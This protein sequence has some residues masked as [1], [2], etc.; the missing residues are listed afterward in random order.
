[1]ALEF[2]QMTGS[3]FDLLSP[4]KTVFFFPV[5]PLEDYG[6]HLPLGL[7]LAEATSL[8]Q[9]MAQ[10]IETEMQG[11]TAVIMPT[12][13][14]GLDTATSKLALSVRPHVL[15]DWLVDACDG[16]IRS[17]HLHFVCF[18][19]N[20]GPKQL[21]AIEEAGALIQK[22]TR[23][24]RFWRNLSGRRALQPL[25]ALISA[26]SAKVSPQTVWQSPLFFA[27][28]EHGGRR[29]TSVA[30]ALDPK[31]VISTFAA[32]PGKERP[33]S[34]LWRQKWVHHFGK[35]QGYWGKPAE[36][37]AQWGESV[38]QETIQELFPKIKAVLEG[39]DPQLL[40]RSWY[41]IF[42]SNRTFFKAWML[43]FAFG[44]VLLTWV[45]LNLWSAMNI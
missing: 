40:F 24:R 14:L 9:R 18:S 30:L 31:K 35:S 42:P 5:G 3:Q 36:S 1:M 28:A 29:D 43:A 27:P 19:G 2:T 39:A 33:E 41:S 21:T 22:R 13:P 8:C 4:E 34:T 15:R 11:W 6:P 17:G 44:A 10:R 38:L 12:A 37:T 45:F 23:W 25:P 7:A 20:L 16:L 32:L 26:S